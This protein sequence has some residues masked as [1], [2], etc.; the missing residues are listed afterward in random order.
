MTTH[1]TKHFEI[2]C[3]DND[4]SISVEQDKEFNIV[5]LKIGKSWHN[6]GEVSEAGSLNKEILLKV[7]QSLQE[8]AEE[9]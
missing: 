6:T 3:R 9:L 8:I 1:T 7:V 4:V 2:Y 5:E